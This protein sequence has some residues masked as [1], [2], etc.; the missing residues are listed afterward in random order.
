MHASWIGWHDQ[1][2]AALSGKGG[3]KNMQLQF[4]KIGT[5]VIFH[6]LLG[7]DQSNEDGAAMSEPM[8]LSPPAEAHADWAR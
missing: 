7:K 6:V 8:T 2:H 1:R 4:G 3:E 5:S